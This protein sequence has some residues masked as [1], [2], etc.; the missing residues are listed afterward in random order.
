M[1][2]VVISKD[3]RL[4]MK[5]TKNNPIPQR[6]NMPN[7]IQVLAT[8]KNHNELTSKQIQRKTVTSIGNC[9]NLLRKLHKH[10]YISRRKRDR[11][12]IKNSEEKAKFYWKR[13]YTKPQETIHEKRT[14][15]TDIE[16]LI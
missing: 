15:L 7:I 9:E 16:G 12:E 4:Y 1:H 8:F 10:G 2:F 11:Y 5:S 14:T 13:N 3:D 6:E